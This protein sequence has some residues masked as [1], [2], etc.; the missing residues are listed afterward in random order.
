MHARTHTIV[1]ASPGR[2]RRWQDGTIDEE[3]G[4]LDVLVLLCLLL[5]DELPHFSVHGNHALRPAESDG[6]SPH[7]HPALKMKGK[8]RT[9]QKLP[10]DG[11]IL[12]RESARQADLVQLVRLCTRGRRQAFG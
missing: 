12:G 8:A 3:G 4:V 1:Y 2:I 9:E 6:V 7:A 10:Y 5:V 11:T